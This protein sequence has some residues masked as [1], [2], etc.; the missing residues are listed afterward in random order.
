LIVVG[1]HGRT[2]AA[3]VLL[4]GVLPML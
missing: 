2:M 3:E 1:S 4:G